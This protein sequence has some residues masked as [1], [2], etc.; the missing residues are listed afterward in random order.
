MDLSKLKVRKA[1][2][3]SEVMWRDLWDESSG[4]SR[5]VYLQKRKINQSVTRAD[6]SAGFTAAEELYRPLLEAVEKIQHECSPRFKRATYCELLG[7]AQRI[8]TEALE[9]LREASK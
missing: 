6:F 3:Y 4:I 5:E 8:V 9:S 1:E 2:E 7:D